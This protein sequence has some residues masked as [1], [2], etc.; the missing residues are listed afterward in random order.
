MPG[1]RLVMVLTVQTRGSLRESVSTRT[2]ADAGRDRAGVA[3]L[4]EGVGCS[5]IRASGGSSTWA[6]PFPRACGNGTVAQDHT[7]TRRREPENRTWLTV[8]SEERGIPGRFFRTLRPAACPGFAR[9][10]RHSNRSPKWLLGRM[11]SRAC[12]VVEDS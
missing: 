2:F 11:S 10:I 12:A 5:R 4:R 1:R 8:F 7:S 9:A 6:F 3:L